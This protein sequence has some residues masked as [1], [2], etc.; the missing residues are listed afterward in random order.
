MLDGIPRKKVKPYPEK[1]TL[2]MYEPA[3][4]HF[5]LHRIHVPPAYM[6]NA[7][8]PYTGKAK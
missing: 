5:K 6:T 2:K 1:P 7:D 4:S 3:E 8:V